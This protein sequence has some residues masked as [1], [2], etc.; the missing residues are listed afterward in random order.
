MAL[1]SV[2]TGGAGFI[3]SNLT[4]HLVRIGHKVIVLDNFVSGKKSNL[5]H[6]KKKDVKIIKDDISNSKNLEKYF[7][8]A[9]YIFHLAAL[10]EVIPSIKN[11]KKYF[12]NN[13]IGTLKVVEAAKKIN[14]KKLIYAASSSCYGN[15][16]KF[17]TSETVSYTHLTLPTT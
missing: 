8:G 3:G 17:P 15:P 13:V 1:K 2:I 12:K 6:H 16:K 5:S 14:I 9:D 11:P 4:D 7:K 10:A